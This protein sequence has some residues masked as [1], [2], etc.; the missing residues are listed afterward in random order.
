MQIE[1]ELANQANQQVQSVLSDLNGAIK[2]I[3]DG[4]H[5]HPNRLDICAAA[6][7]GRSSVDLFAPGSFQNQQSSLPLSFRQQPPGYAGTEQQIGFGGSPFSQPTAILNPQIKPSGFS[8]SPFNQNESL[9]GSSAFG[10]P[11]AP[12]STFLQ[13]QQ[14]TSFNSFSQQSHVASSGLFGGQAQTVINGS[15]GGGQQSAASAN[16]FGQPSTGEFINQQSQIQNPA[17][18]QPQQAV[19][20]NGTPSGNIQQSFCA[21]FAQPLAPML[22]SAFGRSTSQ[23]T[24][25][26][27]QPSM[28]QHVIPS[29]GEEPV[30]QQTN[31]FFNHANASSNGIE[32][33]LRTTSS[34]R[35]QGPATPDINTYTTRD[36]RGQLQTWKGQPVSFIDG[37][38]CY[39]N[40]KNGEW[41]RIWFPEGQPPLS[42]SNV[43]GDATIIYGAEYPV[44]DARAAYEYVA[45]NGAFENGMMPEFP[46]KPE[47]VRWDV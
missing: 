41:E 18:N 30:Q 35:V 45:H 42:Q 22:N 43:A 21:P 3:I 32:A 17:C 31:G 34:S 37:F 24:S 12:P 4:A 28:Q 46:P 29:F 23:Q 16:A 10:T 33:R 6:E 19:Q 7:G 9:R 44:E 11:N 20:I 38:P 8:Q 25:L 14:L 2:Y 40:N 47:W 36:A 26:L 27:A 39:R 5:S 13:P 15:F 1:A